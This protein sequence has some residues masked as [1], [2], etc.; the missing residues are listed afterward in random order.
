MQLCLTIDLIEVFRVEFLD[1][2]VVRLALTLLD[3]AQKT[4][5]HKEAVRQNEELGLAH[6][7]QFGAPAQIGALQPFSLSL[8]NMVFVKNFLCF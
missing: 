2:V 1:R 3:N 7:H 5:R 6:L 8:C 4:I